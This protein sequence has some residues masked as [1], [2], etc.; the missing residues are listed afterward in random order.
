MFIL[1]LLR[2]HLVPSLHVVSAFVHNRQ[3]SDITSVMVDGHWVMREGKVLTIDQEDVVRRAEAVG[4]SVWRRL[5]ERY[6]D[7]P[8]PIDIPPPIV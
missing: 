8:F 7:V 4:H 1:D 3:P 6:P 2:P 5:L